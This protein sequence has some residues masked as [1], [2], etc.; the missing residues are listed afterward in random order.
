[1]IRPLLVQFDER[2][3]NGG[4]IH[5]GQHPL[6]TGP[7]CWYEAYPQAGEAGA[8]QDEGA[9][10]IWKGVPPWDSSAALLLSLLV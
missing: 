7:G 4:G 6:R 1:M 9:H 2:S 3:A 5:P 8:V 10:L